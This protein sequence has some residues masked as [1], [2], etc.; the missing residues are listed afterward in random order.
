[1]ACG[2]GST[3]S[4]LCMNYLGKTS[5]NK[6]KMKCLGGDLIIKFQEKDKDILKLLILDLQKKYLKVAIESKK[7]IYK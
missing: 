5:K 7:Q 1:M 6:I 4:A 2:T 3:A